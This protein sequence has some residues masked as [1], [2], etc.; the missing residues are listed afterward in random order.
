MWLWQWQEVQVLLQTTM[1]TTLRTS[2]LID[3][4]TP[5]IQY[6]AQVQAACKAFDRQMYQIIDDTGVVI[7]IPNIMGL[8]D[9]NLVN[10]L[11]WQFHVDFY[12]ANKPLE[13]RKT[14]VQQAITWHMRKGTVKLVQEVLDTYW[15][16]GATIVEWFEYYSP[17]PPPLVPPNPPYST[18]QSPPIVPAP[19]PSWHDRYRFRVY[20]NHQIIV[21]PQDEADVLLLI[22][23]YKPVSRWCEGIFRAT[24]SEASIGWCG[25]M[26][27][28]I[29][30]SSEAPDYIFKARGYV[31]TG[32]SLGTPA[33]AT[34]PFT[35]QLRTGAVVDQDV[36][37]TPSDA[38]GG[39]TFTPASVT[40]TN[41]LRSATFTYTPATEGSHT[42]SVANDAELEDPNAITIVATLPRYTLSGP[43]S[44]TVGSASTPF[45]VASSDVHSGTVTITPHD[46]GKGGTFTPATVQLTPAA[47]SATFNYTPAQEG[48]IAIN[49]TNNSGYVDPAALSYTS[50]PFNPASIAGLQGWWKAD[51][52]TGLAEGAPLVSWPDS[53]GHNKTITGGCPALSA[54]APLF[55]ATGMNG[56]P[57][58]EFAYNVACDIASGGVPKDAPWTSFIVL[59]GVAGQSLYGL[60]LSSGYGSPGLGI[61]VGTAGYFFGANQYQ[62]IAGAGLLD[63]SAHVLA[64]VI[65]APTVSSGNRLWRDGA[66]QASTIWGSGQDSSQFERIGAFAGGNFGAGLIAEILHYNVALSDAD[67][68]SVQN[69]LLRKYAI[70]P[71]PPFSPSQI[72]GLKGWWS[73]DSLAL[74]DGTPVDSLPDLSGN[75]NHATQTGAA[76]PIFK[77]NVIVR[78]QPPEIA[79]GK[80]VPDEPHISQPKVPTLRDA[81][82]LQL[83]NKPAIRFN[84]Q[85]LVLATAIPDTTWTVFAVMRPLTT[86]NLMASLAS[87]INYGTA[88]P[89]LYYGAGLQIDTKGYGYA[90][91]ST[92]ANF[93]VYSG[94]STPAVQVDGVA[95]SL[96][97]GTGYG[98]GDLNLIGQRYQQLS[99]GDLAELVVYDSVLSAADHG[100]VVNYLRLKYNL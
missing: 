90:D 1:S 70:T 50:Q 6:D 62:W 55:R 34:A 39:G 85:N 20:V 31:M 68:Q 49:T 46:G 45:T 81:I 14:L 84:S 92:D 41:L 71:P 57:A 19:T 44:G 43:A 8:T 40:L 17:L 66:Q 7:M 2:A 61:N 89:H 29:Y 24:V 83:V 48:A 97:A 100:K 96:G 60:T 42:I 78:S 65:D 26:L 51:A 33:I 59:K 9:S 52:I 4:A 53:S 93:H 3:L 28:F 21:T 16:G 72:A 47:P 22:E 98:G 32:P 23:H 18:L 36:V 74:A 35:V 88:G 94:D 91:A 13:F 54:S 79:E 95:K 25:I 99:D 30:R 82:D 10:I 76:R 56:K 5:S 15:P 77:T 37:V 73:A 69:Y 12:D 86:D 80:P 87:T 75:N 58:L 67:R 38:G 27:R 63:T 11:A 64:A